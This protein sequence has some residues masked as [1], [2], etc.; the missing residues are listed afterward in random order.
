[1]NPEPH[2]TGEAEARRLADSGRTAEQRGTPR[3]ALSWYD[4]AL[5]S[6]ETGTATG[7]DPLRA[8]VLR[9]KGTVHRESGEHVQAE[10]LYRQSSK[11]A[12]SIGYSAGE[13]HAA[14]CLAAIA[15]RRGD[16]VEAEAR[17]NEAAL[18][19]VAAGD[20]RLAGMVQQN[21]G[22]LASIRGDWDG[23]L[24]RYRMSLR[25][26]EEMKDEEA[27]SWVLNNLGML[28]TD[29]RR[30]DEADAAFS[31]GLALAQARGDLLVE[32]ALE[33]NRTE[34]LIAAQRWAEAEEGCDRALRIA[35]PRGDLLRTAEALRLVAR[36]DRHRCDYDR[37]AEVIT[38]ARALTDDGEDALLGAEL[39]NELGEVRQ[40]QGRTVEARDAWREALGQFTR[41]GAVQ[42]ISRVE[43]RLAAVGPTPPKRFER[44]TSL[45]SPEGPRA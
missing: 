11:V 18:L 19:A 29:Q 38:A 27:M 24:A 16:M 21:L 35:E 42:A 10:L 13:A 14:N 37:A 41:L 36:L 31:R 12:T 26:F 43:A 15:Q 45:D 9:W 44:E 8:D 30:Y 32:G 7:S 39:L 28:Y 33:V 6:L 23:A 5:E 3:D 34:M 40:A 17:Y 2:L 20:D 25:T 4:R 22:I 1:M